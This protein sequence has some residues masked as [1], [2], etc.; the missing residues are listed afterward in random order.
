MEA[1]QLASLVRAALRP[2]TLKSLKS[3]RASCQLYS[4]GG[5]LTCEPQMI[6]AA[7][8]EMK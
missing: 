2:T 3:P 8:S 6:L 4:E 1:S 5:E 7:T